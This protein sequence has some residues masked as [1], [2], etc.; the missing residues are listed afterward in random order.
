MNESLIER[1]LTFEEQETFYPII[2]EFVF[3]VNECNQQEEVASLDQIITLIKFGHT[4]EVRDLQYWANVREMTDKCLSKEKKVDLNALL[5][6]Y[7]DLKLFGQVCNQVLKVISLYFEKLSVMQPSQLAQFTKIYTSDEMRSVVNITP[8]HL[9]RLEFYLVKSYEQLN[10]SEF[11]MICSTVNEN[12]RLSFFLIK[13][14]LKMLKWLQNEEIQNTTELTQI[15]IAY[16]T[17]GIF[18]RFNHQS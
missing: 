2:E 5:F 7:T 1:E 18:I 4:F 9:D 3:F 12:N 16:M 11:A 14:E 17:S 10:P 15:V 13:S 8:R 6:I